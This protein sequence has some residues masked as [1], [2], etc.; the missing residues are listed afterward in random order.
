MSERSPQDSFPL[1]PEREITPDELAAKVSF[2][3]TKPENTDTSVPLLL[4]LKSN[5]L[6]AKVFRVTLDQT[7]I[8]KM[9]PGIQHLPEIVEAT[10][11]HLLGKESEV[12]LITKDKE[13]VSNDSVLNQTVELVGS[14]L[15]PSD[16]KE[17]TLRRNFHGGVKQY[18]NPS[19]EMVPYFE[20]G[21]HR[22]ITSQELVEQ[23]E[24]LGLL[25]EA[26]Q[27]AI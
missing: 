2:F 12:F 27:L 10:N 8:N 13:N 16:N 20:N 17:G 26:K 18:A 3:M 24:A 5:G 23:L 14:K 4:F 21:F 11:N 15:K 7:L 25:E 1:R 6:Q 9:Y 19:G 22:P